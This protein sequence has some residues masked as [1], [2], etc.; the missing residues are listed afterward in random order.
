[1]KKS[2][3]HVGRT[4]VGKSGRKR[5]VVREGGVAYQNQAD[6]DTINYVDANA[7][8]TASEKNMTRA[9]FAAWAAREAS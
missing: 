3:I 6:C 4:Y 7:G 5:R 9:S 8:V 2:E 1:M